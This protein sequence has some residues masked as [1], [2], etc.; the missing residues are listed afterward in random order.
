MGM[1]CGTPKQLQNNIK[2]HWSQITTTNVI[3]ILKK[4]WNI[5]NITKVWHRDIKEANAVRKMVLTALLNAGLPQNSNALKR[6][7]IS[8]KGQ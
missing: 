8:E 7:E 2:D 6:K 4:V 5:V 3:I 1:V